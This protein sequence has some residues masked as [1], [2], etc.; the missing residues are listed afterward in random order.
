MQ[1]RATSVYSKDNMARS[2]D[3]AD[4]RLEAKPFGTR[5]PDPE[6]DVAAPS[7]IVRGSWE[8]SNRYSVTTPENIDVSST[9]KGATSTNHVTDQKV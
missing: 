8:K 1:G 7:H 9:L 4:D 5:L 2:D 3:A 6:F